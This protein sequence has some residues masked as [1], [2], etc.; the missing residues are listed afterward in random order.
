MFKLLIRN[1]SLWS[2]CVLVACSATPTLPVQPQPAKVPVDTP[3]PTPVVKLVP[4][5]SPLSPADQAGRQLQQWQDALRL[6]APETAS[7]LA[8]RLAAEPA[9]PAGMVHL[10]LAWLHTR[11]PGDAARAQAQLEG[12]ANSTEPTAAAWAGWLPLLTA[13]AA[14][15]KR[16]EE[17]VARQSQQLRDNQRRIDQLTEQLEALKAIERSLAPRSMGK[18]P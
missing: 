9:T 18:A 8:S 14:E 1:L 10:A 4:M 7:G 12:L 16:L 2:L 13:R 6:A 15:Q 3:D 17:Q 11:T 5:P